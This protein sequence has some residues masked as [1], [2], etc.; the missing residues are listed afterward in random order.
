V[1]GVLFFVGLQRGAYP[2]LAARL[3]KRGTIYSPE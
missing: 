1:S 2:R 3:K